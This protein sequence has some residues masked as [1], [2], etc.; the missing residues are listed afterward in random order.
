MLQNLL[1]PIPPRELERILKRYLE[2]FS[3]RIEQVIR[4]INTYLSVDNLASV[5]VSSATSFEKGDS[6]NTFDKDYVE[7]FTTV[8]GRYA[9]LKIKVKYQAGTSS[10][11]VFVGKIDQAS[12]SNFTTLGDGE[13]TAITG[14]VFDHLEEVCSVVV[15]NSSALPEAWVTQTALVRTD[16]GSTYFFVD[17]NIG[18]DP[19]FYEISLIELNAGVK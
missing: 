14:S 12:I 4:Q 1:L 8:G 2:V 7:T 19:V 10:N 18:D 6:V 16:S 13:V 9:L 5:G 11:T 17:T 3:S 15:Q